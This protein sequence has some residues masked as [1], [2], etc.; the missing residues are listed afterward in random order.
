MC[1]EKKEEM[2]KSMINVFPKYRSFEM[3]GILF[4]CIVFFIA[5]PAQIF[6][7][8]I[9]GWVDTPQDS[10]PSV[11]G[12]IAVTGWAIDDNNIIASVKIYWQSNND[13]IY[14]GDACFVDESRPDIAAIY[15]PL[16]YP[17][18]TRAGWGYMMLT[19]FLK[20]GTYTF[21]VEATDTSGQTATLGTKTV[22]IDNASSTLPFGAIDTPPQCG[23]VVWGSPYVNWGWVLTPEPNYIP[24]DGSTI[25]VYV[26]DIYLGHPTYNIYRFDIADLFPGCANS[27]GAVGYFILDTTAY[28]KG[29]HTIWWI[30]TDSN[31]NSAGIGSRSF[32]II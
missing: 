31:G 8:P 23:E 9:E 3:F 22:T 6:G 5:V 29:L 25:D 15:C 19:N 27:N 26:D 1:A 30:V 12:A 10:P 18:C 28:S 21:L 11:A 2:M 13:L 17:N 24:T 32:T 7:E 4:V 14:I 20:D 16:G